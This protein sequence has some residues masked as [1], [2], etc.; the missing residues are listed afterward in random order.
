M[1]G[2]QNIEVWIWVFI[3]QLGHGGAAFYRKLQAN[4]ASQVLLRRLQK[5]QWRQLFSVCVDTLCVCDIHCTIL[6]CS[7]L[8]G[9]LVIP[10]ACIRKGGWSFWIF[11][12]EAEYAVIKNSNI[13][14]YLVDLR[15]YSNMVRFH[16]PQIMFAITS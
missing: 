1:H 5:D 16:W 4:N 7:F 3:S 13:N 2:Q 14:T 12:D 11:Q 8:F 10:V 15:I 6:K 9:A